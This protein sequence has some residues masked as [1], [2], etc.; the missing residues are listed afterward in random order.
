MSEQQHTPPTGPA[1]EAGKRDT[2]SPLE[3]ELAT[4][5]GGDETKQRFSPAADV[6][7]A[8]AGAPREVQ[9]LTEEAK[10][11]QERPYEPQ[12]SKAAPH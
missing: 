6:P 10:L 2:R 7:D 8:P 1:A 11:A 9:E 4:T 3:K 12:S 5:A